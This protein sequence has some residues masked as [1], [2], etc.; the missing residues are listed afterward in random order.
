MKQTILALAATLGLLM[1]CS[2]NE[3]E[4]IIVIRATG[5]IAPK[6]EQ[7]RKILGLTLNIVPGASGGRR[8]INWDAVPDEWLNKALPGDF[9]NATGEG[10]PAAR[11]RGL[12]YTGN[13]GEFRV[14]N[15]GFADVN[16]M[17][18]NQ[19]SAFSGDKAFANISNSLW[20]SEFRVPG[21]TAAATI[22]GFGVVLADVDLENSTFVEFFHEDRSLGK[23]YAPAK[24]NGTNF[25]FVG[26]YFKNEKIT[27]IRIGHD[28]NL[29]E[30]VKDIS[31]GGTRDLIVLDDFL[32]D[33]PTRK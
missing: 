26:V 23:Y 24:T 9:F 21:Q 1:G 8:E 11:Q 27:R 6:V 31:D 20:D 19:F 15:N 33:E 22:R 25:S 18:A 16:P 10:A 32:Y 5:D 28:G 7:F 29:K 30:P 3:D 14:S 2:K 12:T 4:N 17:A 13:D